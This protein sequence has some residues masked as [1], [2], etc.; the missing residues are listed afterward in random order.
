MHSV[1]GGLFVTSD[2]RVRLFRS[3]GIIDRPSDYLSVW[4][5]PLFGCMDIAPVTVGIIGYVGLKSIKKN[6]TNCAHG[7]I[8]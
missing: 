3:F 4:K 5:I 6:I 7:H 2:W 8:F 1:P